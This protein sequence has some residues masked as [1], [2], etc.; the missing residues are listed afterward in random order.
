MIDRYWYLDWLG[1]GLGF[2]AMWQLGHHDRR[3]FIAFIASNLIWV[4]IGFWVSSLAMI[5][6]NALFVVVNVRGYFKW[7]KQERAAVRAGDA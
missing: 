2:L 5:A 4:G 1:M 3:G 7:A 6:G